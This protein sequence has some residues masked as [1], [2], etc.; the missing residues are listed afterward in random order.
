[1]CKGASPTRI[2]TGAASWSPPIFRED[3]YYLPIQPFRMLRDLPPPAPGAADAPT[4]T[5]REN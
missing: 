1:M 5:G 3:L 4:I 2:A